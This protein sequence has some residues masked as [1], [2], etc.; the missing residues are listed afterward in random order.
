MKYRFQLRTSNADR[1]GLFRLCII[2]NGKWV[3]TG[4]KLLPEHWNQP[5]QIITRRADTI[6][7]NNFTQLHNRIT[8]YF[9]S[10][11][12]NNRPFIKQ[13]LEAAIKG[14]EINSIS[15]P[16]VTELINRY[17]Q[18]KPLSDSRQVHYHQ[19]RR[20]VQHL[21]QDIRIQEFNYECGMK[22]Y[23]YYL[24]KYA[25]NTVTGKM[26]RI[27]TIIHFAQ[28]MKLIEE[29]PLKAIRLKAFT[30]RAT[31][32]SIEELQ[33][34]QALYYERTLPAHQQNALHIFLIA[35]YT[36]LRISDIT[37]LKPG[38]I[39]NNC[40]RIVQKK[41]GDPTIIPLID[42]SKELLQAAYHIRTGQ[43]L[44]REL[45]GIAAAA[46]IKKHITMHV[47]RHTFATVA[48]RLGMELVAVSKI[49][50]HKTIKQTQQYLHL[51]E[52]HLQEQMNLFNKLQVVHR[53]AVAG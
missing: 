41:T 19:L 52:D 21:F 34:L 31:V 6:A 37:A 24:G 28:A 11:Q 7:R 5:D 43:H 27:K 1:H 50:G 44:N 14:S 17:L 47:G 2:I 23:R 35:C 16:T 10:L 12:V 40:I 51:L 4:I 46:G 26:K 20:E 49:L 15:N 25:D 13:E 33:R 42:I 48:L 39:Q 53:Q 45:A 18:L 8:T 30:N 22:L 38:N 9:L 3:P 36:G 32:L 29:D